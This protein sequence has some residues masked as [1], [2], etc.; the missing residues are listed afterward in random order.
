[1][2]DIAGNL[3][4]VLQAVKSASLAAGR[5]AAA[6][7]LVAVSKTCPAA[8]IRAAAAAGQRAFGENYLQ[9]GLAKIGELQDLGLEWHFIGPV[10]SNKTRELAAHF[11]WIHG[12]ERLKIAE[13]LSAQRP[14]S[15]PALNVCVQ[16]NV[17]GEASKSGC[18]PGDAAALCAVV[19]GLP[20][21]RLRGLM[22]IPEAV[23]APEQARPAFRALHE[24]HRTIRQAGT[25]DAA[26]FDTLSMGMSGDFQAAIAEGATLVRI[27]SA[28]FGARPT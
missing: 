16:V 15:L 12:V 23:E 10:Q 5:S 18:A 27:G 6:V 8:A 28:I 13:R 11:D 26:A 7:R 2:N 24:L 1:M 21:L 22:A 25:V 9:E 14:E 19:A 3:A 20:R 17:S 4:A